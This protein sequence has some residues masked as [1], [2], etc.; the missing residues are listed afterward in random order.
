MKIRETPYFYGFYFPVPRTKYGETPYFYGVFPCPV[1]NTV[2]PRIFT[3][4]SRTPYK[5][6]VNPVFL[7]DFPVPRTVGL[8]TFLRK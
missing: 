4:V 3:G 7:R 2:K 6:W 8:V 1:Q 5:I